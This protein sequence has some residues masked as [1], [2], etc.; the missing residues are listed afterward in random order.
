[1]ATTINE[2]TC[3]GAISDQILAAARDSMPADPA[4]W[5][6]DRKAIEALPEK[7]RPLLPLLMALLDSAEAVAKAIDDNAWDEGRPVDKS[8]CEEIAGQAQSIGAAI[9]NACHAHDTSNWSLPSMTG[10]ELV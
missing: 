6:A 10:K 9:I 7:Q 2:I 8:L 1:M 3:D 5:F 4:R